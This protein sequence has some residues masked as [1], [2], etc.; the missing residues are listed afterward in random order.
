[1][2]LSPDDLLIFKVR[3]GT[4]KAEEKPA[5]TQGIQQPQ[6]PVREAVQAVQAPISRPQPQ[7]I[8]VREVVQGVQTPVQARP[9]PFSREKIAPEVAPQVYG[10]EG[11]PQQ[12]AELRAVEKAPAAQTGKA[13]ESGLEGAKGQFCAW[14]AWRPAYA[15]CNYC[16]RPFCYE[17]IEELNTE[18]YCLEDI[19]KVSKTHAE[20]VYTRFTNISLV[21]AVMLMLVFGIFVLFAN[22]QLAYVINAVRTLGLPQFVSGLN[23]SYETLLVEA[24]LTFLSLVSA[25]MIVMQAKRA[26]WIGTAACIGNVGLFSYLFLGSGTTY[27]A[28]ITG[29]SFAGLITLAYSRVSYSAE[30]ESFAE[31][32]P[33]AAPAPAG[34]QKF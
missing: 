1:M 28:L 21:S 22:A 27:I 7:Q 3:A 15:V 10:P 23:L 4:G 30:D 6:I 2:P 31:I 32:N 17:D 11:T 18:Y 25:I 12:A 9:Q 24:A 19:D 26:F 16:H 29:V 33:I 13:L 5:A 34:A 8:P 14:H 20:G